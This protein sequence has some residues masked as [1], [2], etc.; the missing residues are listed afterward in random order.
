ML[1]LFLTS[2]SSSRF[3]FPSFLPHL[4]SSQ[5]CKESRWIA[6]CCVGLVP[7]LQRSRATGGTIP[8]LLSKCRFAHGQVVVFLSVL[9]LF[10]AMETNNI[11]LFP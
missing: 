9:V 6:L 2:S 4:C 11:T 7:C 1:H 5:R 8:Y 3:F 10:L